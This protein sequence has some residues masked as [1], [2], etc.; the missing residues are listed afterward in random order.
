MLLDVGLSFGLGV[1]R[2]LCASAKRINSSVDLL[3]VI[4]QVLLDFLEIG[5]SLCRLA[6][7]DIWVFQYD[8][9]TF[10]M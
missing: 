4:Y 7:R 6:S 2:I 10:S 3:N 1:G 5:L 9:R 8:A